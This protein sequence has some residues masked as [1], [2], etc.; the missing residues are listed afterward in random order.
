MSENVQQKHEEIRSQ[1]P[2]QETRQTHTTEAEEQDL[3]ARSLKF[4]EAMNGPQTAA[5]AKI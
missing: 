5:H 1:Q 3:W 4:F 2:A